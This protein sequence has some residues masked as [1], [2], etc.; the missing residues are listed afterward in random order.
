MMSW[1][2]RVVHTGEIRKAYKI[3]VMK[4]EGR[5]DEKV[6]LKL[7]VEK[8]YGNISWTHLVELRNQ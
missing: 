5:R 7:V 4:P 1:V 6:I 2:E 3:S 8:W